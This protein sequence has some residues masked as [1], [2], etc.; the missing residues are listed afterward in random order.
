MALQIVAKANDHS[1]LLKILGTSAFL[2]HCPV[3]RPLYKKLKRRLTCSKFKSYAIEAALAEIDLKKQRH[4]VWHTESRGMHLEKLQ[5][6]DI[7]EKDFKDVIVQLLEHEF[8]SCEDHEQ[9]DAK[10]VSQV[11]ADDWGFYNDAHNNFEKIM[12]F[13]DVFELIGNEEMKQAK[14]K[15]LQ[16]IGIIEE[17]PKTGTWEKR[18]ISFSISD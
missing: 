2:H 3:H 16:L 10:Y 18:A 4:Y 1:I 14:E 11:L 13:V 8:G 9:I 7:T 15:I 12:D 5:I 17:K 6:H